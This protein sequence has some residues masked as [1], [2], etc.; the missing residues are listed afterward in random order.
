MRAFFAKRFK[1]TNEQPP[2]KSESPSYPA[3][4]TK[5]FILGKNAFLKFG[6]ADDTA[7]FKEFLELHLLQNILSISVYEYNT[8]FLSRFNDL[9]L[10]GF[11]P[12][13]NSAIPLLPA[14]GYTPVLLQSRIKQ[15]CLSSCSYIMVSDTGSLFNGSK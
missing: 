6:L 9:F 14:H 11:D 10:M 2:S 15:A 13:R 7:D 12:T 3:S 4:K 1:K 8:L 5:V